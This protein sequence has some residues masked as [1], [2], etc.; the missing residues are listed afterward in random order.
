MYSRLWH[1][2][3]LLIIAG[4]FVITLVS[5]AI[6]MPYDN[7]WD[8]QAII[9][10]TGHIIGMILCLILFASVYFD[11]KIS[12]DMLFFMCLISIEFL[13]LQIEFQRYYIQCTDPS[14]GLIWFAYLLGNSV[15]PV[16]VW[17]FGN[18]ER[19]VMGVTKEQYRPYY[20]ALNILLI[21]ITAMNLLQG[22]TS[23]LFTI[24]NGV[25][26]VTELDYILDAL[27]M[28]Q[29]I[30]CI[31]LALRYGVSII[32]KLIFVTY[33]SIPL[34]LLLTQVPSYNPSF[35][36]LTNLLMFLFMYGSVY[37]SRGI[38]IARNKAE[39]TN[40]KIA[41]M[42]SRIEPNFL[43]EALQSIESIEGNPEETRK[44][45]SM[46]AK[47]LHENVNTIS[48]IRPIAFSDELEHVLIYT[49]LEKL[50]FKDHINVIYDIRADN[51]RIPAM[52][53]QM[54]VENAIKHGITQREEGG[55]VT[56]TSEELPD[57][58]RITVA[59]DGVGFDVNAPRDPNRS[60]IGLENL[61]AR[62]KNT[63]GGTFE[64]SSTPGVGTTAVVTIP[65]SANR[66]D[67]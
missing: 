58:F 38:T 1:A 47:Y 14:S 8:R 18:Y 52:T 5:A 24:E 22:A 20:M 27:S 50:R 25:Y 51:F 67:A 56:V 4:M 42:V 13:L 6:I 60:H 17:V 40:R 44:A 11:K 61:E 9:L 66:S 16:L 62:L 12:L 15:F 32:Q 3:C 2:I 41:M 48:Q 39:M 45:L 10:L 21:A 29:G 63:L 49:Y 28:L 43:N 37:M 23:C 65:K 35:M 33:L 19:I 7:S 34:I 64:I 55:T 53:V 59:D 26:T 57:A 46:F 31:V 54:M 30:V 36:Y